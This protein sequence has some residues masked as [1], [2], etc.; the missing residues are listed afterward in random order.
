M[1]RNRC[2][3][4]G[5]SS[6]GAV[7]S[8]IRRWSSGISFASSG[9]LAPIAWPKRCGGHQPEASSRILDDAGS[10]PA[11]P[12]ARSI[13]RRASDAPMLPRSREGFFCQSGFADTRVSEQQDQAAA[14][15]L[16]LMEALQQLRPL[17]VAA[18]QCRRRCRP[19]VD[20]RPPAA[21]TCPTE[22]LRPTGGAERCG[23]RRRTEVERPDPWRAA[24]PAGLRAPVE[25][26][27]AYRGA[28]RPDR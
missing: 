16:R 6:S 14:A 10:A 23:R 13:G 11:C 20:R 8:G 24:A 4:G 15:G 27:A 25:S 22:T 28:S 18:N 7:M 3:N 19:T 2:C 26:P 21:R 12:P 1:N 17:G 5:G 9:A